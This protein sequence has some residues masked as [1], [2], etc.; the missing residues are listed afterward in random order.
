M[1]QRFQF[2]K[3]SMLYLL[4][5]LVWFCGVH[6]N[7]QSLPP[8]SKVATL[9][10][11]GEK[12]S[13]SVFADLNGDGLADVMGCFQHD[14]TGDYDLVAWLQSPSHTFSTPTLVGSN[15]HACKQIVVGDF[16]ADGIPDVVTTSP[17]QFYVLFIAN[18]GTYTQTVGTAACPTITTGPAAALDLLKQC[19]S[20]LAN[21]GGFAVGPPVAVANVPSTITAYDTGVEDSGYIA[22]SGSLI[23]QTQSSFGAGSMQDWGRFW[24]IERFGEPAPFWGCVPVEIVLGSSFSCISYGEDLTVP[25]GTATTYKINYQPCCGFN[26]AQPLAGS[27]FTYNILPSPSTMPSFE[28]LFPEGPARG[29]FNVFPWDFGQGPDDFA[30]VN[31][32]GNIYAALHTGAGTWA[33][34]RLLVT[35]PVGEYVF[36]ARSGGTDVP[37]YFLTSD[38]VQLNAL[39]TPILYG[40]DVNVW[41][42]PP[43]TA[44]TST[45]LACTP[46]SVYIGQ[47][48][49]CT[50]MV[51]STAGTPSCAVTFLADGNSV[52]VSNTTSGV[53]TLSN[54]S[55][56]LG[57]HSMTATCAATAQF[58]AST[59]G[60]VTVTVTK[61]PTGITF[62]TTPN[63]SIVTNP[64]NAQIQVTAADGS[65]PTGSVSVVADGS[66]T[67]G[68]PSL[69]N[70]GAAALTLNGLTVGTHSIAVSYPGTASY[71]SSSVTQSQ[72]VNAIPTNTVVVANPASTTYL[73][74]VTF[75]A[76]VTAIQGTPTGSVSFAALA[77]STSIIIG[78]GTLNGSGLASVQSCSLSPSNYTV[79]AS[80]NGAANFAP[81]VGTTTEAV[82]ALRVVIIP[83]TPPAKP[84]FNPGSPIVISIPGF[85]T[86]PGGAAPT[87]P[88]SI[89]NGA[90]P[91][92]TVPPSGGNIT[93]TPTGPGPFPVGSCYPG[94]A[95]YANTCAPS[96]PII[97]TV[98]APTA[99]SVQATPNPET[100]GQTASVIATVSSAFGTPTGSVSCTADAGNMGTGTVNG[101]GAATLTAG[102][103]AVGTHP[104]SC[105][106]VPTG[107]FDP[108]S[109]GTTEVV[110]KATPTVVVSF[111]PEPSYPGDVVAISA[112]VNGVPAAPPTG[113]VSF[114]VDGVSAGTATISGRVATVSFEF[115]SVANHTVVATYSGDGSYLSA[116]GTGIHA[117]VKL[118]T[119]T[120]VS[121][122]PDPAIGGLQPVTLQSVTIF[123]DVALGS[124]NQRFPLTGTV[125]FFDG[126]VSLGTVAING[127]TE[128]ATLTL[129][130][131]SVGSHSLTAIYSGDVNYLASSSGAGAFSET[132]LAPISGLTISGNSD[133]TANANVTFSA[134]I[135]NP[136][137]QPQPTGTVTWTSNGATVGQSQVSADGSTSITTSFPTPGSYALV[138]SYEGEQEPGSIAFTQNVLSS[139]T[140]GSAPFTMT[141]PAS[142]SMALDGSADVSIAFASAGV[143]G[144]VA[145][146]CSGAPVGYTCN[147]SPS[148]IVLTAGA[149]APNVTVTVSPTAP[150]TQAQ[151]NTSIEITVAGIGFGM[152]GLLGLGRKRKAIGL[153]LLVLGAFASTA[154]L[155][156]CGTSKQFA[157]GAPQSY[158]I[159]VTA[160]VSSYKESVVVSV[161]R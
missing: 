20:P 67:L 120:M 27:A 143:A 149:Q 79:K 121:A 8:Y 160:A 36:D 127:T 142:V 96:A 15:V 21:N 1:S 101:S 133:T 109:G 150:T 55:L 25:E 124:A 130:S 115:T 51:T 68:V 64:V 117:V 141:G 146:T 48:V 70:S 118:P 18:G 42:A 14:T 86:P 152:L 46:T 32:D 3:A 99:V 47:K 122:T 9:N 11:N 136:L 116:N 111:S 43:L 40:T 135:V 102:L 77:G 129:P 50:A 56:N 63:P 29:L 61:I 95:N 78:T 161:K 73:Q 97:I 4:L 81:S 123:P 108:S 23:L 75:T 22:G 103:L 140:D 88:I 151:K 100:F 35:V 84:P 60:P 155:S 132:M 145:L 125:Q 72:A 76:T 148:S 37:T 24:N 138:A 91:I 137:K 131:L 30:I 113:T 12:V 69:S 126:G 159:T 80:Y 110:T 94:D 83:P 153:L 134:H 33:A 34:P 16:N 39:V 105:N 53:A 65:I 54:I 112:S 156:G 41:T 45:A 98:T 87:Q 119:T 7:S 2:L 147:L 107:N 158:S 92:G 38:S 74:C 17:G 128:L 57:T 66:N 90:N 157:E 26:T 5:G 144:P 6:A 82:A 71:D 139:G 10:F 44:P 13:Y 104:I 114:S 52:G 89:Y 49:A 93:V 85:P 62:V 154:A 58:Q 19:S 31:G 28:G 59:G 106:Y